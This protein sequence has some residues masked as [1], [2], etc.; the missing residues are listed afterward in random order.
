MR[1]PKL[2][3][4]SLGAGVCGLAHVEERLADGYRAAIVASEPITQERWEEV[5]E[6]TAVAIGSDV[7][8]ITAPI[9]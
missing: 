9:S 5:A 3:G 6:R 4:T 2:A 7:D 8:M 1:R